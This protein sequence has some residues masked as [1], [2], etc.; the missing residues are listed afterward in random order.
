LV[1]FVIL[2]I[3]Y[4]TVVPETTEKLA[5]ILQLEDKLPRK[6]NPVVADVVDVCR[7]LVPPD[8]RS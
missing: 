2:A 1:E 8:P 6:V 4:H 5:L 7:Y 3:L